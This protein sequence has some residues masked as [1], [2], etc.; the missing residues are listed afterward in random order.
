MPNAEERKHQ[1]LI[2]AINTC[3]A[4]VNCTL[5]MYPLTKASHVILDSGDPIEEEIPTVRE[6]LSVAD[7]D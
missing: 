3:N 5:G 2:D 7:E 1:K 4:N 6:V